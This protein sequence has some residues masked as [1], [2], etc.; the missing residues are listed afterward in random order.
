MALNSQQRK[1]EADRAKTRSSPFS[2]PGRASTGQH[3]NWG[4]PHDHSAPGFG[5]E[6]CSGVVRQ[7]DIDKGQ[8]SVI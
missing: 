1:F 4:L 5:G 2:R 6:H 8:T 3:S 7:P